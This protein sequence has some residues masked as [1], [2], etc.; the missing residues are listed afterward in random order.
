[1]GWP[2]GCFI[3]AAYKKGPLLENPGWQ[4]VNPLKFK[5]FMMFHEAPLTI[6]SF[7]TSPVAVAGLYFCRCRLD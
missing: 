7:M 3:P 5:G 2:D 4:A 6:L 1:M